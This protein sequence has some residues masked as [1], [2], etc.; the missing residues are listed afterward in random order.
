MTAVALERPAVIFVRWISIGI[1]TYSYCT[2]IDS[3]SYRYSNSKMILS[4]S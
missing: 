2:L 1:D 4:A 3:Y